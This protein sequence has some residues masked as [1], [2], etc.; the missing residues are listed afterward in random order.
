MFQKRVILHSDTWY[1][2]YPS[3]HSISEMRCLSALIVSLLLTSCSGDQLPTDPQGNEIGGEQN[4]LDSNASPNTNTAGTPS[5][6][7][8]SNNSSNTSPTSTPNNNENANGTDTQ[9]L[10]SDSSNTIISISWQHA[11]NRNPLATPPLQYEIWNGESLVDTVS[12]TI[13]QIKVSDLSE[14]SGCMSIRAIRGDA[15]S[16]HSSPTCFQIVTHP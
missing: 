13:Y 3:T 7:T 15:K 1:L 2:F 4:A 10:N 5:N 16:D 9:I 12:D 11:E 6:S 14:S 8:A